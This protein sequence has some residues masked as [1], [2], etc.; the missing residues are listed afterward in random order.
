MDE[1]KASH[2]LRSFA[3]PYK[4]IL[5]NPIGQTSDPSSLASCLTQ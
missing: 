1:G 3:D 2:F 4:N 5:K